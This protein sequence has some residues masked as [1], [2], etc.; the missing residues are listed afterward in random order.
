MVHV[1]MP[2]AIPPLTANFKL[3][4]LSEDEI[5]QLESL[6]DK[7]EQPY[8]TCMPGWLVRSHLLLFSSL[9]ILTISPLR[10]LGLVTVPSAFPI[11]QTKSPGS[12]LTNRPHFLYICVYDH[13]PYN[14]EHGIGNVIWH[15]YRERMSITWVHEYIGVRLSTTVYGSSNS[16]R[17]VRNGGIVI[18]NRRY[19]KTE[20]GKSITIKRKIGFCIFVVAWRVEIIV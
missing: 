4:E 10:I 16:T 5:K 2:H 15:S 7:L 13:K 8:R 20:S 12:N 14:S 1:S 11:A 9:Y 3:T 18:S 19:F 17:E 6:G